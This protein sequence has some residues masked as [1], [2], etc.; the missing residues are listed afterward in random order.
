MNAIDT[1]FAVI[2]SFVCCVGLSCGLIIGLAKWLARKK[3]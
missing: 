3:P 1:G 2:L